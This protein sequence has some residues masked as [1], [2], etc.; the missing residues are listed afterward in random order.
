MRDY[1]SKVCSIL[2]KGY[3]LEG[4]DGINGLGVLILCVLQ[5]IKRDQYEAANKSVKVD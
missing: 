5:S 3:I 1:S 4:T 2:F